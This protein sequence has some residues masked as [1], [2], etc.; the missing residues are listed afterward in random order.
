MA[1][2][3]LLRVRGLVKEYATGGGLFGL[4][5]R[6]LKA[7][8]GVD[9]DVSEGETL[10]LVGESGSGKTTTGR[11]ILRLVEPTAGQIRFMERDWLALRGSE[12][13]GMRRHMQIIFQD[14][15][16]SLNPRMSIGS[17]L[18]EPFAI[19]RIARGAERREKVVELLKMVGLDPGTISRYPGQLSGGQRQRVGFARAL[20]LRPRLIVCDE[21]VSSLDVSIQA[22][23]I[24]LLRDLQ[25]R[26]GLAYLFIAHDLRLVE[27]LADRV[28]VMYLGRIVE[29]GPVERIFRNPSH[30]YTKAL[31]ASVPVTDPANRKA[32]A[33]LMGDPPSPVDPPSGCR[34]HTRCSVAIEP[35]AS[36]EPDLLPVSG[37]AP[38]PDGAGGH[39]S[40]CHLENPPDTGQ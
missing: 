24:N 22:Q 21:P 11:C 26:L 25:E 17:T 37:G 8:D 35:C 5:R 31:L 6:T 13:R 36:I 10:A 39:L 7:V 16:S 32:R 3:E 30:P 1:G 9:L 12:L 33:V 20:A 28:A 29:T 38:E 23:M 14:P 40:A 27:H 34:F 19:H 15:F 4:G 2:G 18:S